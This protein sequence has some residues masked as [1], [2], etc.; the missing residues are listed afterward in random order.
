MD[1]K[2]MIEKFEE[3]VDLGW[4]LGEGIEIEKEF[5][6]V[7]FMGMGGSAI[8]A[9]IISSL[10]EYYGEVL[11]RTVK[12]YEIPR[13]VDE[14]TLAV[15]ISYSGNTEE[16]LTSF[17]KALERT[18]IAIALSSGGKLEELCHEKGIDHIK[19]RAGFAPRAA[20]PMTFFCLLRILGERAGVSA[21]PGKV[22]EVL[23]EVDPKRA[24]EIGSEVSRSIPVIYANGPLVPVAKRWANQ[25]NENA[26]MLAFFGEFPEMNHNEIVGWGEHE[27]AKEFSV[28]ILESGIENERV[29][30]R[31]DLTEEIALKNCRKLYRIKAVGEGIV[32]KIAYL[33]NFNDWI[34]Y[35]AAIERGVDPVEIKTI[36]TLK[37]LMAERSPK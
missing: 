20:F 24:K 25:F 5:D 4:K 8:A 21:N 3:L 30:L 23:K 27:K 6:K 32:E 28:F 10:S 16:T 36:S 29:R 13:W 2:E 34:S 18:K 22:K 9:E 15:A 17:K 12:G 37:K 11:M 31:Y 19:L 1:M 33:V 35:Y 26:K 14:R 7:I